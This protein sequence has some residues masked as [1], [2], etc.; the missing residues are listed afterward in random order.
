MAWAWARIEAGLT[1]EVPDLATRWHAP[2]QALRHWVLPE[3]DM[4]VAIVQAR[5]NTGAAARP[6]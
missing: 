2:A 6:A 3:F 5:C 4:R 1:P